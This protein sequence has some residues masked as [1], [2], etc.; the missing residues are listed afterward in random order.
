MF[1]GLVMVFNTWSDE[2]GYDGLNWCVL[3][4][5]GERNDE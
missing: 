5:G 3:L 4:I 1:D 2:N